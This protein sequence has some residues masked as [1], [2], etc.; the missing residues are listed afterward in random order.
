MRSD[1]DD[2]GTMSTT[3]LAGDACIGSD[4]GCDVMHGGC[5]AIGSYVTR[6][7]GDRMM[8]R[9]GVI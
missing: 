8:V 9:C 1:D 2:G 3:F 7:G 5:D 4:G 6:I